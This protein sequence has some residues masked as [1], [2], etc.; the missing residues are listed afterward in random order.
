MNV[1][2]GSD[3][4]DLEGGLIDDNEWHTLSATFDRD[5]DLTIYEDGTEVASGSL[6]AIGDINTSYP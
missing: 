6:G 1:G 5:G 3:R 4:V 2:D